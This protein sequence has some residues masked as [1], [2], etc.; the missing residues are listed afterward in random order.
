[1]LKQPKK[2]LLEGWGGGVEAGTSRRI[3]CPNFIEL[4]SINPHHIQQMME[5]STNSRRRMV[6]ILP[7]KELNLGDR[8]EWDGMQEK[9]MGV[10]EP[11]FAM[12]LKL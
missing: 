4:H 10:Q 8:H 1:M 12:G 9:G 11:D 2:W 7:P 3:S 5:R 6:G